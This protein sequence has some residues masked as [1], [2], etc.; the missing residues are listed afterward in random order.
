M[1]TVEPACN[2]PSKAPA[3]RHDGLTPERQSAFLDALAA[4]GSVTR[5]AQAVGLSRTAVYNLRNRQDPGAEAFRVAWD[6]ALKQAVAVLA[7]TAFERALNGVEE[8]VFHKGE[9]VGTRTRHNDKLLMFLLRTLDPDTYAPIREKPAV[10]DAL[11]SRPRPTQGSGSTPS[12]LSTLSTLS[13]ALLLRDDDDNAAAAFSAQLHALRHAPEPQ[14]TSK[15][16]ARRLAGRQKR[17]GRA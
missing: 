11:P 17:A 7:E 3:P 14:V 9:Q 10:S 4:C 13:P 5:A 8:P 15:R 16:N 1:I 2:S 12:T 6:G